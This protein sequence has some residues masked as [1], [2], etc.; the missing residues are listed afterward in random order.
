MGKGLKN[1]NHNLVEAC[2][3]LYEMRGTEYTLNPFFSIYNR[4]AFHL[5]SLTYRSVTHLLPSVKLHRLYVISP[6]LNFL[7]NSKSDLPQLFLFSIIRG[8][9]KTIFGPS[10]AARSRALQ[11]HVQLTAVKPCVL[12]GR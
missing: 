10:V 9:V 6:L 2:E 8:K 7:P 3:A 4:T 11:P 12:V 5:S 1:V